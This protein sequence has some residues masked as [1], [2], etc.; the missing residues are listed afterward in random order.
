MLVLTLV[1]T[2]LQSSTAYPCDAVQKLTGSWT[3]SE[4][5]ITYRPNGGDVSWAQCRST[6]VDFIK[7]NTGFRIERCWVEACDDQTAYGCGT[8]DLM[9]RGNQ[10][11]D[12][13][14]DASAGKKVGSCDQDGIR[15][16]QEMAVDAWG[17]W[18]FAISKPKDGS[19][20]GSSGNNE[21]VTMQKTFYY[22]NQGTISTGQISLTRK[23]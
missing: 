23:N 4:T 14:E 21:Q 3:G 6:Y 20:G 15:F 7:T 16:E 8:R 19:E 9:V 1:M 18:I 5:T 13:N 12:I 2:L 22:W 17:E 10:I 11:F